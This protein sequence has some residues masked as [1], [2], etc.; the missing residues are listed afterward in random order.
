L[1]A[2]LAGCGQSAPSLAQTTDGGQG[3]C[4]ECKP[5]MLTTLSLPAGREGV[6]YGATLTATGGYPPYIFTVSAGKLPPGLM[7]ESK[8]GAITGKPTI[9]GRFDFTITVT[10]ARRQ[11]SSRDFTIDI[12]VELRP[13]QTVACL[14]SQRGDLLLSNEPDSN[15]QMDRLSG[16]PS[17]GGAGSSAAVAEGEAGSQLAFSTSLS[18]LRA[19]AASAGERDDADGRMALGGTQR[20]QT[21]SRPSFDIWVEGQVATFGASG[22]S[23]QMDTLALPTSA[24]TT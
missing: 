15:R 14:L 12:A 13:A 11:S 3:D 17:N 8:T 21:P 5:P 19:D 1:L 6:T 18:Q 20:P 24:P 4:R 23:G 7:L 2:F 10:D 9:R 22:K 16:G